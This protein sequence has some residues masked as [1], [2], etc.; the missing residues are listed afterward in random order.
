MWAMVRE[1]LV[2]E[3]RLNPAVRDLRPHV[4]EALSEK[5]VTPA[6]GAQQILAALG[7][8]GLSRS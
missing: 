7:L 2:D 1:R 8:E 3:I 6:Q 5:R 4:E